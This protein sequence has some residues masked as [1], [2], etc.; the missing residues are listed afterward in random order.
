M[1][2]YVAVVVYQG[3]IEDASIFDT[4]EEANAWISTLRQLY[5]WEDTQDSVTWDVT[6]QEPAEV[7]LSSVQYD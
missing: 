4:A 7:Q 5:G 3:L 1:C 2:R 6:N